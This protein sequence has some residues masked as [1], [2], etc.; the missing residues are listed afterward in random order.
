MTDLDPAFQPDPE[1]PLGAVLAT[2]WRPKDGRLNDFVGK[3]MESASHVE[4]MGGSTR[5]L[6]IVVGSHPLTIMVVNGFADLDAFGAYS[7]RSAADAEWQAFWNTALNEPTA[8][9][10]RSGIYVNITDG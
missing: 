3:V 4:R 8:D 10:V 2:Q 1:R 6:Q 9:L 7:D 5:A